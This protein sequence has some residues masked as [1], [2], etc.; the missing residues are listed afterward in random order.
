MKL[1]RAAFCTALAASVALGLIAALH[2]QA[3][4]PTWNVPDVQGLPSGAWRDTVLYGRLLFSDTATVIGPEVR[5]PSMRFSGNN[6][7]CQSCHLQGGTQ[8]YSIPMIGVY[9]IFPMF[10]AREN[11]VRTIEDRIEGCME[12]SMNGRAL[13]GDG[14]EMKAM[15]AYIQFLSTG[16]PIGKTV[17]GRGS[18]ALPLLDRAASP[19]RGA[20]VYAQRCI[21]CHRAD[22]QGIRKG[23]AG[24]AKGYLYPPV[25]GPDSFN[26]GA[27]MHRLIASASFIRANMPLGTRYDMPMLFVEDAWDVAAYINTR[28]RPVREHLDR[29]YPDRSRKPVDAPFPPFADGFSQAQHQFGP[30]RPILDAQAG[31]RVPAK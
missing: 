15:V 22:G 31:R 17:E 2:A 30:F 3:L 20:D 19:D 13:P 24:D 11:E 29:D 23:V 6:L 16:V 12:R 10:M 28:P 25:W 5:D 8:Q 14:K 1:R 7:S 18:P 26:D 9:A 4:P 27:G 21:A